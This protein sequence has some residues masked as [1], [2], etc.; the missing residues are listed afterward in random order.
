MPLAEVNVAQGQVAW[1]W[2]ARTPSVNP[3]VVVKEVQWVAR[4]VEGVTRM[5]GSSSS[6][7]K[8][9]VHIQ[10]RGVWVA[11]I[12]LPTT[13]KARKEACNPVGVL[14]VADGSVSLS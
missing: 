9:A 7:R 2:A 1:V 12:L 11:G 10:A 14:L 5:V 6:S 8:D 3:A 13:S 4:W